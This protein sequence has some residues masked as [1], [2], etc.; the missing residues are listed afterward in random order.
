MQIHKKRRVVVSNVKLNVKIGRWKMKEASD[1]A[2]AVDH[3]APLHDRYDSMT[4]ITTGT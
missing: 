2:S 4:V 3:N 1:E